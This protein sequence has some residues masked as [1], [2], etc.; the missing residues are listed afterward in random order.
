M[1]QPLAVDFEQGVE[2]AFSS[3]ATFV[4]KLV[5][6]LVILV[7]G[8][9]VAKALQKIVNTLLERVGFDRA[10]ERGGVK[11]ALSR[12]K[13][14]ASD[15]LAKLVYYAVLLFALQMAFAVFG[16][17]PV[18]GLIASVIAFLPKVFVAILIVVIAAA[19]AKAV[20]DIIT[21]A[22]GGLS[23]GSVLGNVASAFILGIG[24]IAAL[25]QVEV[26]TT[27][28][29]PLLVAVLA[30]IGG[31]LVVGVGGGLIRPMSQRLES[32]LNK[33][34]SE[35]ETVRAQVRS[36]RSGSPYPSEPGSAT[37]GARTMAG[38]AGSAAGSASVPGSYR[39]GGED[40]TQQF[41]S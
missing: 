6:F 32:A 23:Y 9:F 19:I 2:D 40:A 7:I 8:F 36:S 33:A 18:S 26:A 27:V 3:V 31:I 37:S 15:I 29:T 39:Q 11:Q 22:L 4:P 34:E 16:P 41:R 13:Y 14:D 38:S 10:V 1:A 30:T 25:N 5:S 21:G 28:T 17:N 12:S 24:I 20:K 35:S